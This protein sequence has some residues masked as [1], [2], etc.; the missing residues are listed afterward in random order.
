MV[1]THFCGNLIE[2]EYQFI[3]GENIGSKLDTGFIVPQSGRIKKIQTKILH[4]G[5]DSSRNIFEGGCIFY[6]I[7]FPHP[8]FD[9]RGTRKVEIRHTNF[10]FSSKKVNSKS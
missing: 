8:L 5:K 7:L 1:H 6:G 9:L 10:H 2:G 3:F 4:E